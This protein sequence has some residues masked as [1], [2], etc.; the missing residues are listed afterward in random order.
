M[1]PPSV[2]WL[3][4]SAYARAYSVDRK[5]VYKWLDEG[6]LDTFRVHHVIRILHKPP[7]K[8]DSTKVDVNVSLSPRTSKPVRPVR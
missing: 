6:L 5:T 7:T 1:T 3:S 4:I 2:A 8:A